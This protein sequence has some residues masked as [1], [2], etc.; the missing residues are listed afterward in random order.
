MCRNVQ[1]ETIPEKSISYYGYKTQQPV[2]TRLVSSCSEF[3]VLVLTFVSLNS[4]GPNYRTDDLS[5]YKPIQLLRSA[6]EM[7]LKAILLS[8]TG[9]VPCG[10]ARIVA[11]QNT[12]PGSAF[13]KST[14]GCNDF[15]IILLLISVCGFKCVFSIQSLF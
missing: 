1:S 8:E 15:S 4:S 6:G 5:H 9:F 12:C 14:E 13:G 3:K 7:L 2:Q 11:L 10:M